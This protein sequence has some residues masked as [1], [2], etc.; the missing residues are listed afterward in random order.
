MP[1]LKELPAQRMGRVFRACVHYG[2]ERR[3]QGMPDLV[4]MA[5][6]SKS[7]VYNRM[8]DP[9]GCTFHE[10]LLFYNQFFNDRQLCEMFGVEYHG[11]TLE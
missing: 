3:G 2:L 11:T 4:R 10:M 6:G 9:R 1:K 8:H 5:P 7:T